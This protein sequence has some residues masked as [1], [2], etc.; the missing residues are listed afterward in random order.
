MEHLPPLRLLVTF[1]ALSRH[2]SM[3][4]AAARL[5][6]TQPAVSQAVKAL[7][8]HVGVALFDRRVRPARLTDAGDML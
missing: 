5:N 4:D 8:E 6:V 1:E 3:R 7:E 2:G